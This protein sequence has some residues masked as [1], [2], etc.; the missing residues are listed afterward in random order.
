[1]LSL[2]NTTVHACPCR[3]SSPHGCS[4]PIQFTVPPEHQ[5]PN[6]S[7]NGIETSGAKK[8]RSEAKTN[9]A[10]H[11]RSIWLN[12]LSFLVHRVRVQAEDV[13]ASMVDDYIDNN[14][15]NFDEFIHYGT[16]VVAI[17][18]EENDN[19]EDREVARLLLRGRNTRPSGRP[20]VVSFAG[21][22]LRHVHSRHILLV[23]R[24]FEDFCANSERSLIQFLNDPHADAVAIV[25]S[26][27]RVVAMRRE[28]ERLGMD[29]EEREARAQAI[30][31]STMNRKSHPSQQ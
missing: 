9:M 8:E 29:P 7:T 22:I 1:M 26:Y 2:I 10:E 19:E 12:F 28:G 14:A 21:W 5:I 24:W 31:L 20:R 15:E 17:L 11:M 25:P 30:R 13:L 3:P 16:V 27:P 6:R 18:P 4:P 23:D